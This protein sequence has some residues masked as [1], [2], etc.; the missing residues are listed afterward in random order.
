[1]ASIQ[2]GRAPAGEKLL[3]GH[4]TGRLDEAGDQPGPARLV[5]GADP[6][7][8]VPVEVFIE[9]DAIPPVRG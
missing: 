1:M 8:V 7:A 2:E 3:A 9:K 4:V 6:G 5:A